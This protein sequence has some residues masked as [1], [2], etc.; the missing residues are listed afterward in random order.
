MQNFFMYA[1]VIFIIML[2]WTIIFRKRRFI[3]RY[4]APILGA[5]TGITLIGLSLFQNNWDGTGLDYFAA[6]LFIGSA[7]AILISA[8]AQVM[9]DL[10]NDYHAS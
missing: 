3:I 8:L 4:L 7:I 2:S 9:A 5:L 1:G 6:Y 10:K